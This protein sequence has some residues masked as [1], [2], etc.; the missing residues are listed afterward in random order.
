MTDILSEISTRTGGDVNIWIVFALA[1]SCPI[2]LWTYFRS[3]ATVVIATT[4]GLLPIFARSKALWVFEP[5]RE[6]HGAWVQLGGL[7]VFGPILFAYLCARGRLTTGEFL[8]LLS[9]PARGMYLLVGACLV[10]QL[11]VFSFWQGLI[12]TY[13]YVGINLIWF[14]LSVLAVKT[15]ADARLVLRGVLLAVVVSCILTMT[16][17]TTPLPWNPLVAAEMLKE[18]GHRLTDSL[19]FGGNNL[20]GPLFSSLLCLAPAALAVE[21]SAWRLVWLGSVLLL[22]RELILTGVRG[23][24]L[25]VGC[26]GFYFLL[27]AS[28]P[29]WRQWLLVCG[30]MV[31][32]VFVFRAAF[33]EFVVPRFAE[34]VLGESAAERFERASACLDGLASFPEIIVGYGARSVENYIPG[35]HNVHEGFLWVWTTCGLGGLIG[36]CIWLFG[37]MYQGILLA[38]DRRTDSQKGVVAIGL[39]GVIGAWC[40]AFVTTG[41]WFTGSDVPESYILLSVLV[42]A[43]V[44]LS[45]GSGPRQGAVVVGRAPATTRDVG[46]VGAVGAR[47]FAG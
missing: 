25:G 27:R 42:G 12:V 33:V 6:Y 21:N 41:G 19:V 22:G 24:L 37:A 8:R 15:V 23:G 26:V 20:S 39:A 35:V 18:Q 17:T 34:G 14:V 28:R 4:V 5:Y 31:G 2:L 13:C 47:G 10:T 16:T 38:V 36:F 45:Q 44:G 30:V 3:R 43:L 1:I 46:R 9:M 40:I 29:T 11:I 32:G 7:A